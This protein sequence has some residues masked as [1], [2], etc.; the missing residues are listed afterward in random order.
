MIRILTGLPFSWWKRAAVVVPVPVPVTEGLSLGTASGKPKRRR[1][2][3]DPPEGY[4]GYTPLIPSVEAKIAVSLPPIRV[5]IEA[6]VSNEAAIAVTLGSLRVQ[7]EAKYTPVKIAAKA[8]VTLGSL[9]VH[10]KANHDLTPFLK[11]ED[12]ELLLLLAA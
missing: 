11:R 7:A 12:G 1:V 10:A 4:V 5:Q 3:G 6:T 2:Y 9:R 8:Q